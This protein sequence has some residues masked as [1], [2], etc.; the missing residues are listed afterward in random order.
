MGGVSTYPEPS[1]PS[2][3]IERIAQVDAEKE[4][5]ELRLKHWSIADIAEIQH[6]SIPTVRSRIERAIQDR[7]PEETRVAIRKM[8]GDRLDRLERFQWLIIESGATTL[9]EKQDAV[10][11]MLRIKE[12]R[13]RMFGLDMPV[14]LDVK[15]SDTM[16]QE[17]EALMM[18]L[19]PP[20]GSEADT[21][22][23][24]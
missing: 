8:E 13:A 6:C 16:D 12:R 22:I 2:G 21:T 24:E 11:T 7:I 3:T 15:Y 14:K 17:I 5:L 10:A 9:A 4:A 1:D 18:Q 23:D 20:L 19:A